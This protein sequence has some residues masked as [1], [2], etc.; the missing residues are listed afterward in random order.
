M[1]KLILLIILMLSG[2]VAV[3][4]EDSVA[5]FPQNLIISKI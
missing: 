5:N 4:A 1:K 2:I 3:S